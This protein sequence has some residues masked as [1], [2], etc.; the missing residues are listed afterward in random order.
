MHLSPL[1]MLHTF[2][3]G[4][5]FGYFYYHTENIYIPILM[6]LTNNLLWSTALNAWLFGPFMSLTGELQGAVIM[7]VAGLV[8]VLFFAA[9]FLKKKIKE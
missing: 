4:L 1:M 2:I 6:H 7:V 5:V 3:S 8:L 9:G